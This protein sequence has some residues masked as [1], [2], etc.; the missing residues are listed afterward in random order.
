[1]LFRSLEPPG[2]D[3]APQPG[4]IPPIAAKMLAMLGIDPVEFAKMAQETG[5]VIKDARERLERIE[6]T[7]AVILLHLAELEKAPPLEAHPPARFNAN[8]HDARR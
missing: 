6:Q 3:A 7:Q 5:A 2:E 1:M 4:G 8:K